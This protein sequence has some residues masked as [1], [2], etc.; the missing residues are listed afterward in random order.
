MNEH[1]VL[2]NCLYKSNLLTGNDGIIP[3]SLH[4]VPG[5]NL[6]LVCLTKYLPT[7]YFN[8]LFLHETYF[9]IHR[10]SYNKLVVYNVTE[11]NGGLYKCL[12]STQ[13]NL[14]FVAE[15]EV[16]VSGVYGKHIFNTVLYLYGSLK[17]IHKL[18]TCCW[19]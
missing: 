8:N 16:F 4:M 2:H 13:K 11:K 14:S 5:D 17:V 19:T 3:R 1:E 15:T 7:W 12:G 9:T 18:L 10:P 6:N